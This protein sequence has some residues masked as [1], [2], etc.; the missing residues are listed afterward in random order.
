[1]GALGD[2]V[3]YVLEWQG[4]R[5]ATAAITIRDNDLLHAL[6]QAK[7]E[8]LPA[9]VLQKL[10]PLLLELQSVYFDETAPALVYVIKPARCGGRLL[11]CWI[12]WGRRRKTDAAQ[13]HS[14]GS[15]T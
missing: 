1:M 8:P 13:Q 5:P 3:L 6:H 12:I 15:K 7:A 10:T 9:Y 4:K 14:H 2:D 11:S